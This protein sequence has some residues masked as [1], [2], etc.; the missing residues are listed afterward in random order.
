MATIHGQE[1]IDQLIARNGVYPG[2]ENSPT[3]PVVRIV[4]YTNQGG[5]VVH[6]VVYESEARMGLL[7]RYEEPS[8]YMSDQV[9]I[10]HREGY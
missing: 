2:D 1:V 9:M 5:Q 6:G 10:W 4:R 3:G 7:F 8:D